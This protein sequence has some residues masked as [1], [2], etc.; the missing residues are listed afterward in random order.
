MTYSPTSHVADMFSERPNPNTLVG[1]YVTLRD[2]K[3]AADEQYAAF[4]EQHYNRRM[5]EI[6]TQ[7]LE[8]LSEEG[9]NSISGDNGTAYKKVDTS[10]TV[11]DGAAF[12]RHVIGAGAWDLVDFRAAKTPIMEAVEAGEGLPPGINFSQRVSVGIRR[13]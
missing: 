3:K 11:A 2:Q 7:L 6:E 1:E 12:R 5:R 8:F 9:S 13:K 10:V 4:I